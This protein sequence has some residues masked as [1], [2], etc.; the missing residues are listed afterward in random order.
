VLIENVM[1]GD[2]EREAGPG[3]TAMRARWG[4]PANAA[5]VLYTGTFESY[6]GLDLLV[7]A[8]VQLQRHLPDAHVVVVGG[9]AEQVARE[10]ERASAA[11][12]RLVFT[13]QRPPSEI[14]HFVDACDVLVSPRMAGTNTPLKIYSYLRS[15]RPIVATRLVTHTQVLDDTCACLV[16]PTAD[17]LAAGLRRMIEHPDEARALAAAASVLAAVRYSREAYVART[18]DAYAR[19]M[20]VAGRQPSTALSGEDRG[21]ARI[22]SVEPRVGSPK[23]P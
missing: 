3:R 20:A 7:D 17:A 8:S 12:A 19:L 16:E 2:V 11:G 10:Q 1:G 6:Q 9:S 14:P 23:L 18:R 4:I 21:A 5:L 22:A 15:N 13:G